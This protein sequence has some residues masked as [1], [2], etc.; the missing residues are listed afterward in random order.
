ML[1]RMTTT[2]TRNL[3]QL[4]AEINACHAQ[5]L[6]AARTALEHA[7]RAGLLL[8]EAKQACGH[9]QWL[10]WLQ[11]N[12]SFSERTAQGYIQIAG[13]WQELESN[14]QRIADLTVRGALD[15]L[16]RGA[17]EKRS[18]LRQQLNQQTEEL[19]SSTRGVLDNGT[20]WHALQ[21]DA[22]EWLQSLP[23]DAADLI[24]FSPPYEGQRSY[25]GL[26][27]LTGEAWV[28][29]Y[30][31]VIRQALQV[32]PLVCCVV[33]GPTENYRWAASPHLLA[34]D[35]FRG[36][37]T[38]RH[39]LFYHRVGIPGSG[40]PDWMRNDCENILCATRGGP[41]PWSDNTAMGHEPKYHP[42]GQPSHRRTDDSRVNR[43]GYA[44]MSERKQNGPHRAR[45]RAGRSYTP[46]ERAN[47][48][49]VIACGAVGGGNMGDALCH[50]N[51]APFAE[52][53]AEFL[54]RSFCPPRGV[55]CDPFCGSGT[56]LAVALKCGR[57]AL[58]CDVRLSQV[59]L[60]RER[61]RSLPAVTT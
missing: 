57:R 53:L 18:S 35:L 30:V 21:A 15:F 28:S 52:Y 32:A 49:N 26:P 56:T 44:T 11:A 7:R 36:G 23:A 33:D 31:Q 51:E 46:P 59:E 41:L 8:T 2:I 3:A 50:E 13:R 54:I 40:G 4:A 37:V 9:G 27:E 38:L 45:R 14:P 20:P 16:G 25:D 47:P 5:A 6:A 58:G 17:P 55:V 24:L 1:I 34:A 12:V 60:T 29:R 39:D 22:L 48:G 43:T 10:P 42:G 19:A 61:C